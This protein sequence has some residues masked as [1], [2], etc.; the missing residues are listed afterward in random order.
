MCGFCG[1]FS[2]RHWSAAP[3]SGARPTLARLNVAQIAGRLTAAGGVRLVAWGDRFQLTGRT[4]RTALAANLS[5]IWQATD[6]LGKAIDPL[7]EAL[8][9]RLEAGA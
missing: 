4:G 5:E 7:D 2:E 9:D 1:S 6:R 3:V 8:L